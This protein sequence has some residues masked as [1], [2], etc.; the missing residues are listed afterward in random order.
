MK[1]DFLSIKWSMLE[2]IYCD[3]LGII[4]SDGVY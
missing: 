1:A 3:Y 4:V 2:E